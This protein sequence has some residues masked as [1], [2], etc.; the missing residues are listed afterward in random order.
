MTKAIY[1]A[2]PIAGLTFDQSENW[3]NYVKDRMPDSIECYSPL[4][5]KDFLRKYGRIG[6]GGK[7][8]D[9][10][11]HESPLATARGLMSRDHNDVVTADL[12]FCNLLGTP[13]ISIGTIMEI[14]WCYAY[15]KLLVV[16]IEKQGNL[17]DHPMIRE[18]TNFACDSLDEGIH[19][20]KT[21]LLP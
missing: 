17:H 11:D 13:R 12:V 9:T 2:G 3:R 1:L 21:I 4:R 18:A 7:D 5:S 8:K 16:C 15:R 14:A 20:V 19:L 6:L 10:Y